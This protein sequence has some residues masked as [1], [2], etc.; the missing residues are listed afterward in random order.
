MADYVI[1]DVHGCMDTLQRLL[2]AI[3]YSP[4]RD[5]IFFTGDLVNGGPESAAVV[6]WAIEQ[7]ASAVL[8]NHDLHLLAVAAGVRRPRSKDTFS[9]LLNAKDSEELLEWLRQRPL[10]IREERFLLVHAGVLP[11]WELS[12]IVQLSAEVEAA[13]RGDRLSEFLRKMYGDDPRRW[14]DEL[15]GSD[16]L[17]L[18][19]NAMTRLRMLTRDNKIDFHHKKKP[20]D[21]TGKLRAW[22]EAENR[23][24]IGFPIFFGHWA[25]LG[26]YRGDEVT[27]L[28]SGC[29]WGG[30]L[31]AWRVDGAA[32]FQ[33]P[34][35]MH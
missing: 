32:L 33:A 5:R 31:T 12:G 13:L 1:G 16:R 20:Q 26:F 17:R 6:R 22:F 35:E 28:D 19:V 7:N 2:K 10:A 34:A 30:K 14:S 29:V 3:G 27:G 23:R 4:S 24:S 11:E 8:G 21:N 9:D 18:I 25:A 15:T